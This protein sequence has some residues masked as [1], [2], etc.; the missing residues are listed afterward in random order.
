MYNAMKKLGL[1]TVVSLCAGLIMVIGT[2]A[3]SEQ[4]DPRFTDNGDGTVTDNM[5]GLIWMK[6]V[7]CD[8]SKLWA[9]ALDF[10]ENLADGSCGL[11]DG[12]KAGDWRLPSLRELQNLIDYRRSNPALPAGHPFTG[13]ES[14]WCW[15]STIHPNRPTFSWYVVFATGTVSNADKRHDYEVWC[16]RGGK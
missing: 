8:G 10:C 12:S 1:M 11:S 6:N 14:A 2:S 4:P 13:V 7:G 9:D 16:V 15:S 5:T 3:L